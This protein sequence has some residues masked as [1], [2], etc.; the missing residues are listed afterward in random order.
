M[1]YD[2]TIDLS[3]TYDKV[4]TF[5][6]VCGILSV[7]CAIL[8]VILVSTWMGGTDMNKAYLGGFNYHSLIFNYHPVC[9]VSG[10]I[11][12]ATCSLLSYRVIPLPKIWTKRIHALLHTV[13]MALIVVGLTTVVVGNNYTNKNSYHMYYP[14]F[15]SLHSFLG[16]GAIFIYSQ[17]YF[18]GIWHF[19]SSTKWVPSSMRK[20]YMPYHI[21][22]GSAALAISAL[23]VESGIMELFTELGC[24]Y[25]VTSPDL[26]P[27]S[28]YHK[29]HAGCKIANGVGVLVA[30]SVVLT[31]FALSNS[32]ISEVNSHATEPLIK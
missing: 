28:N 4:T 1:L 7:A 11:L 15:F 13:S 25:S 20:S 5:Q 3:K 2:E 8:A 22:L 29:L 9:M 6:R 31:F 30:L 32:F 10:L 18:L 26:D 19:L 27:A 12:C 23:A 16:L 21:Y 24:S 14:N 17:N